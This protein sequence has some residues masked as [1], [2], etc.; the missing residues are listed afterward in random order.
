M[1]KFLAFSALTMMALATA[2]VVFVKVAERR[3]EEEIYQ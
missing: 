2:A 1:K 3:A